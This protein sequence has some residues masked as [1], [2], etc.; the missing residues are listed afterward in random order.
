[1]FEAHNLTHS[2][3]M[4]LLS[5]KCTK[6]HKISMQALQT[7]HGNLWNHSE[8][9]QSAMLRAGLVFVRTA[10]EFTVKQHCPPTPNC[11]ETGICLAI[12]CQGNSHWRVLNPIAELPFYVHPGGSLPEGGNYSTRE[13]VVLAHWLAQRGNERTGRKGLLFWDP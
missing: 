5:S 12:C 10:R 2:A 3:E 9:H 11:M 1:M 6:E 7:M 13:F 4:F 8:Q